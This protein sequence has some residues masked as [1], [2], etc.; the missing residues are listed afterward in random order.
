MTFRYADDGKTARHKINVRV[1][2][3]DEA[4]DA[5]L[6]VPLGFECNEAGYGCARARKL[7][8]PYRWHVEDNGGTY[9]GG[10]DPP[11]FV[12]E[13]A[14]SGERQVSYG[15]KLAPKFNRRNPGF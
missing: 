6:I 9:R 8:H 15:L 11:R 10:S 14:W 13:L 7:G 4:E 3:F 2:L 5:E 12:D 1:V